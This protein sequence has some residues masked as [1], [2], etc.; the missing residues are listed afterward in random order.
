MTRVNKHVL[1]SITNIKKIVLTEEDTIEYHFGEYTHMA[2]SRN[3]VNFVVDTRCKCVC[4]CVRY[5]YL[6]RR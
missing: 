1:H 5:K 2:A 4:V 6:S 3:F